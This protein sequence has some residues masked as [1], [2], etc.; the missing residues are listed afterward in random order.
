MHMVQMNISVPDSLKG[1]A[2]QRV[3]DGR[4]GSTSDYLTDLMQRDHD[5]A[6]ELAWL[7]S[8]IDRGRASGVDPRA[9]SQVISDVIAE[10]H[11]RNG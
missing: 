9:P 2:E 3:R 5:A 10:Y 7:Q 4:Y 6:A 11:P 8:E 1:W